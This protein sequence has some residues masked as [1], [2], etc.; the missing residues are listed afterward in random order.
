MVAVFGEFPPVSMRPFPEKEQGTCKS[1]MTHRPHAAAASNALFFIQ[2]GYTRD[3][4][5]ILF[6]FYPQKMVNLSNGEM[7][8]TV[9]GFGL[10]SLL[11]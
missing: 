10:F 8:P 7:K 4:M 11:Y 1:H 9:E 6:C 3:Q 5:G 2:A